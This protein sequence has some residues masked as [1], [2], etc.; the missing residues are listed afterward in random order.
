MS[1]IVGIVFLTKSTLLERKLGEHTIVMSILG[2]ILGIVLSALMFGSHTTSPN[3]AL[4]SSMPAPTVSSADIPNADEGSLTTRP[5]NTSSSPPPD[6]PQLEKW[7]ENFSDESGFDK[8]SGEVTNIS[9]QAIKNVEA[10]TTF[11]DESGNVVKTTSALLQLNPILPGQTSSYETMDT[12][13]PAIKR[14]KTSFSILMGGSVPFRAKTDSNTS[15]TGSSDPNKAIAEFR[16]R[17]MLPRNKFFAKYIVVSEP[18]NDYGILNLTMMPSFASLSQAKK[19]DTEYHL[20]HLWH[21]VSDQ[22]SD[23]VNFNDSN[24]K[25]IGSMENGKFSDAL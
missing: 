25:A 15:S 5:D 14:E 22:D 17:L 18:G 7:S 10:E 8:V 2:L 24:N 13:N 3:T 23:T 1:L 9:A 12:D 16:S 21:H 6:E 11:Y 20:W 4:Y 19:G